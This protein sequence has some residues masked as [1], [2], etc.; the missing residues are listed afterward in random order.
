ME[1]NTD[2]IAVIEAASTPSEPVEQKESKGL[3]RRSWAVI[4]AVLA[5]L[6]TVLG[7]FLKFF[8]KLPILG[9]FL[10]IL[11]LIF[12]ASIFYLFGF[13]NGERDGRSDINEEVYEI[14]GYEVDELDELMEQINDLRETLNT[15]RE[16]NE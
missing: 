2:P 15:L 4:A 5:V 11:I 10:F 12:V 13:A 3:I 9:K 6:F 16:I 14:T 7:T 1:E 8:M